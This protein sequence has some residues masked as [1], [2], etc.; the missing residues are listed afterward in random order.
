M[1][2]V[3]NFHYIENRLKKTAIPVLFLHGAGGNVLSWPPNLRTQTESNYYFLELPG[4]GHSEG[5]GGH[6]IES[7]AVSVCEFMD[8]IHLR[9]AVIV[10]HSM[11]GA[12]ALW[13]A[14][15]RPVRVLGLVLLAS[16]PSF[17]VN[18]SFLINPVEE[19]NWE[20][21]LHKLV[22]LSFSADMPQRTKDLALKRLLEVRR[23]V[24]HND[25]AACASFDVVPL[26]GKIHQPCLIIGGSED[27][28]VHPGHWYQLKEKIAHAELVEFVGAGHHIMFERPAEVTTAIGQFLS[29]IRYTPGEL[30][31]GG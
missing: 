15:H 17:K 27:K 1:P 23:S 10:G 31:S 18:P 14:I 28:M 9:R 22:D 5:A 13:M 21:M 8:L 3:N 29:T 16:A 4:H 12:I 19:S 24:I 6:S 20:L 2:F 30:L 25:L 26:V 7:M 11:G